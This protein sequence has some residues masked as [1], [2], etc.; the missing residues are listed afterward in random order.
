MKKKRIPAS[1]LGAA[2]LLAAACSTA[3]APGVWVTLDTGTSDSFFSV[4]FVDENIGWLNG[5]SLRE[6]EENK[7]TNSKPKPKKPVE[8]PLKAN[9]GFEVLQTTDG[10]ATWRQIP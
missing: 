8:D 10:G 5:S 6:P 3:K 9:Q 7:N 1:L 4:N 2:I